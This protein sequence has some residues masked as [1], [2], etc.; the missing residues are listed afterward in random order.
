M[1][2]DYQ[3]PNKSSVEVCSNLAPAD[4]SQS[5]KCESG[6]LAP[7]Q[8]PIKLI[9]CSFLATFDRAA[10]FH[11]DDNIYVF[12]CSIGQSQLLYPLSGRKVLSC[13]VQSDGSALVVATD[14]DYILINARGLSG[15][16]ECEI[17][18]RDFSGMPHFTTAPGT[19]QTYTVQQR[20]LSRAYSDGEAVRGTDARSLSSDLVS[21][22][23]LLADRSAASG[24]FL[25]PCVA[26]YR[27]L[28]AHG[29]SIF[30]SPRILIGSPQACS[31]VTLNFTDAS[32]SAVSSYMYSVTGTRLQLNIPASDGRESLIH[33]CS[34]RL[35]V[36]VSPML[37]PYHPSASIDCERTVGARFPAFALLR[38]PGA[39]YGQFSPVSASAPV[40]VRRIVADE[41][42]WRVAAVVADPFGAAAGSVVD[43]LP[44]ALS[45]ETD[46]ADLKAI[47]ASRLVHGNSVECRIRPPHRLISSLAATASGVTLAAGLSAERFRGFELPAIATSASGSEPWRSVVT[48]IFKDGSRL[49]MPAEGTHG[50]PLDVSPVVTYPAPDV[51]SVAIQL[52]V[53]G[54]PLRVMSLTMCPDAT[55]TRSVAVAPG[56]K[57]PVWREVEGPLVIPDDNAGPLSFAGAVAVCSPGVPHH[58]YSVVRLAEGV[59]AVQPAARSLGAWDFGRARF[60]CGGPGGINALTVSADRSRVA[61]NLLD[62][63]PVMHSEAMT[64]ALDGEVAAVA[65]SDLVVIKGAT[66]TTCVAGLGEGRV[67]WHAPLRQLWHISDDG[68]D[69][70]V[71]Y[72]HLKYK[73]FTTPAEDVRQVIST[74]DSLFLCVTNVDNVPNADADRT[75][76]WRAAFP[77]PW[78][79]YCRVLL[80]LSA[81]Y[82]NGVV[83]VSHSHLDADTAV[84][85]RFSINGAVHSPLSLPV[86]TPRADVLRITV[87][88]T[89]SVDFRLRK[90]LIRQLI[91]PAA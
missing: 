74:P 4:V 85:A 50:A 6:A 16:W 40:V 11:D 70:E 65:G 28:D 15:K 12:D 91:T 39:A 77:G 88:G 89:A 54:S 22:Y 71:F 78:M 2:I 29:N 90:P 86:L 21:A 23:R 68:S 13:C 76:A 20:T 37:Q 62:Q 61:V 27:L 59:E 24:D 73:G 81:T 51:A 58:V 18:K 84:I 32:R 60:L 83:T 3:K 30:E 87:A 67:G 48:T 36:L 19:P 25:Q 82:F 44:P 64:A 38:L 34:A 75:V 35:E 69:A 1:L 53:Q 42:K 5:G 80:P 14:S 46:I 41:S 8:S 26:F 63:R 57:S 66:V 72:P 33:R 55:H 49:S 31:A 56:L 17:L 79:G 10:F 43:I 9:D 52:H 45:V 47:V 7:N